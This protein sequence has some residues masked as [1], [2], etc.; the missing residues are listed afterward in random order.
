VKRLVIFA[1]A[2]VAF[3]A[4]RS[5]AQTQYFNLEAGRPTRVEDA[6][7]TERYAL[8]VQ[9]A[10]VRVERLGDG[11]YRWRAEP[12]LSFGALPFTEFE[13][14][15]P[16]SG[17]R[18]RDS[19]GVRE[20]GVT[21]MA[22]GFLRAI[23]L[24]T[25]RM[26]AMALAAEAQLPVGALAAPSATYSVKVLATK[27][28]P[29]GRIHLNLSAGTYSVRTPGSDACTVG[30]SGFGCGGFI[31]DV[32]C[33]LAPVTSFGSDVNTDGSR[34]LSRCAAPAGPRASVG[35]ALVAADVVAERFEGFQSRTDMTVEAGARWQ[36]TPRI[37]F[38]AGVARRFA[39]AT[40]SS[41][42]TVGVTFAASV[43]PRTVVRPQTGTER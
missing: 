11:S 40:T 9:L 31:P 3:L 36:W 25:T 37:V 5:G 7:A 10:P 26:P 17:V 1:L 19:S 12:K 20:H 21:G 14:R 38:D 2:L 42:I 33:S 30:S 28:G 13:L 8:D 29:P 27:S 6:V 23:N 35:A 15:I 24:E 16:Y 34:G 32:P 4:R 22:I 39:G 18:S 41:A 43:R